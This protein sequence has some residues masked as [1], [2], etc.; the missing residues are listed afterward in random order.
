MSKIQNESKSQHTYIKDRKAL[1]CLSICQRYKMKANHNIFAF[2]LPCRLV[3]YQY[4]KD[5]KWKQITTEREQCTATALLFINM[6]KIQNESKSQQ[7]KGYSNEFIGCLSICQRY[8]MKAN[9]NINNNVMW[10]CWVVYQY[11]KDTKWKQI[12]TT[13]TSNGL[14]FLLFINMSKI[15]NESKSQRHKYF[16]L[17]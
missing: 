16:C 13:K 6:S 10:I 2:K 15:Q 17:N 8:K 1:S 12:T 11:V 5:T 9:H 14:V 3:V 4:V 7:A